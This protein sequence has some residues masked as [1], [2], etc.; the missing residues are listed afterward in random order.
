M[1]SWGA[2]AISLR[3]HV[4]IMIAKMGG[5]GLVRLVGF[6]EALKLLFLFVVGFWQ[7]LIFALIDVDSIHRLPK[8]VIKKILDSR[9]ILQGSKR[10]GGLC[11]WPALSAKVTKIDE[12]VVREA[13]THVDRR[14]RGP[15][16]SM[17]HL[18]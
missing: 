5:R 10:I 16:H 11:V 13:I 6:V 14:C 7:F 3:D 18:E 9:H 2:Y 4:G 15:A 17:L 12:I 1:A 8:H